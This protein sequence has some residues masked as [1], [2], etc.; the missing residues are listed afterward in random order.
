[1]LRVSQRLENVC[2]EKYPASADKFLTNNYKLQAK[3]LTALKNNLKTV[4][5]IQLSTNKVRQGIEKE[6]ALLFSKTTQILKTGNECNALT[7]SMKNALEHLPR[8]KQRS[9]K[10]RKSW[11]SW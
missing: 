11:K 10:L 3:D 6:D 8:M 1:M 5:E 4:Q 7:S 9:N 2:S